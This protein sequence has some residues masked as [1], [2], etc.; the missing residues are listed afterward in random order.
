MIRNLVFCIAMLALLFSAGGTTASA[1]GEK[2]NPKNDV[3][4]LKKK[5]AQKV[6]AKNKAAV[7]K[8]D[9]A[10]SKVTKREG[11][12]Y[13]SVIIYDILA[14]GGA[15]FE[16]AINTSTRG[17]VKSADFINERLLKNIDE[18]ASQYATYAKFTTRRA[19]EEFTANRLATVKSLCSRTPETHLAEMTA[20]YFGRD[21][22]TKNPTGMEYGSGLVGQVAHLGFFIPFPKYRDLYDSTLDE[23][24][25]TIQKRNPLGYYGEDLM[26][27]TDVPTPEA[28]SPYTPR[29]TVPAQMSIN[30]GEYN[31]FENAED[32]YIA[33][34][35]PRNDPK[36]VALQR[37]FFSALQ[38]PTR[39]YI[40]KVI[41]NIDGAQKKDNVRTA[42]LTK[43]AK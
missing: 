1:F 43:P 9:D 32:S 18:L 26:V 39:F 5:S 28:Q 4:R 3:T 13:V 8:E 12:V 40:F 36:I 29:A 35:E 7:A 37:N 41:A 19:A 23:V 22:F 20:V 30:Y 27:E 38:V 14:D 10:K 2:K 33:R 25:L 24:K 42:V 31:T 11:K 15:A 16:A 21:G 34:N 17:A 6:N